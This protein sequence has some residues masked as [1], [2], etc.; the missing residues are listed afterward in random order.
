MKD[1]LDKQMKSV[2]IMVE[3]KARNLREE[4]KSELQATR[5]DA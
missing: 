4:V 1:M 5:H 2:P 3:Q